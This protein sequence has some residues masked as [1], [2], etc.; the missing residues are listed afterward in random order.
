MF[1]LC[2]AACSAQTV[3][4]PPAPLQ[5]RLDV[6]SNA[7][8]RQ[9]L[10]FDAS[11]ST[12]TI[13]S[14]SFDFGDGSA[15]QTFDGP[16]A[17]AVNHVYPRVGT[18]SPSLTVTGIAGDTS[19]STASTTAGGTPPVAVLAPPAKSAK[20]IPFVFDASASTDGDGTL[21]EYRFDFGD[22]S[23]VVSQPSPVARHA[24]AAAGFYN[25]SVTVVS[26]DTLTATATAVVQ[27]G[28]SFDPTQLVAHTQ[29]IEPSPRLAFDDQ[30]A[31]Y[32][33]FN[34]NG[35]RLMV[36]REAAGASAFPTGL[37]AVPDNGLSP[38]DVALAVL[39]GTLHA[40]FGWQDPAGNSDIAYVRSN[41]HGETF[42]P[43]V[44]LSND[45]SSFVPVMVTDGVDG[46]FVAYEG[47]PPPLSG[48]L[49]TRFVR[50]IDGG[51]T[52]SAPLILAGGDGQD[53][54]CPSVAL[55]GR[56][57]LLVAW[58]QEPR[59]VFVAT[60]TDRGATFAAPVLLSDSAHS[61]GCPRLTSDGA[62]T[63]V[64][65]WDQ[66]ELPLQPTV[67]DSIVV[68]RSS[69]GGRTWDTP[70]TLASVTE[71][72]FF[73][74]IEPIATSEGNLD[75]IYGTRDPNSRTPLHQTTVI[76]LSAD[77]GKTNSPPLPLDPVNSLDGECPWAVAR[78]G[79]RLGLAW[80]VQT[81]PIFANDDVYFASVLATP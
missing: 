23:P 52:F 69:D 77:L 49:S 62:G 8:V 75:L 37:L 73:T 64:A 71:P 28:L 61:A 58:N 11:H 63:I 5:A 46:I 74:C 32:V 4:P 55:D 65:I 3:P 6:P 51:A 36:S 25:A 10:P 19:T 50:S 67:T 27:V 56:G 33:S 29:Q 44:M 16:A 34:F 42:S 81:N 45:A 17:P 80:A 26:E 1:S 12:G 35:L 79:S 57:N 41:D 38:Q 60:S 48:N 43:P 53:A 66:F 70:R 14:Y 30:D 13:A 18:Y 68:S 24:Y 76:T 72:I 54:S 22:G 47:I 31:A 59:K 2:L 40:V 21:V 39:G 9:P 15:V 7:T 20:T 78:S